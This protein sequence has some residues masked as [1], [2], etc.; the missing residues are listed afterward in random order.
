M[1]ILAALL[2]G[3]VVLVSV[4]YSVDPDEEA[5]ILRFGRFLEITEPG[6]HAKLPFGIDEA[7][8]VRTRRIHKAEFGFRTVEAGV[9]TTYATGDFS[10]ESQ[11]LTGDLNVADVE[12]I[13]QYRIA[14]PKKFLF[15]VR[16]VPKTIRDI[17]ESAMRRVV[18]DRSVNDV[19]TTGRGEIGSS[20][21]SVMQ[22]SI[23]HY[24]MGI[25]IVTVKLQDVNPPKV[26]KASFNDVNAAKQEEER[27][28]NDA[29]Q[30]Y[31]KAIPEA[32]GDALKIVAEAEGY[33]LERVNRAQ[34]EAE[35]FR[36]VQLEYE[37]APKVTASRLYLE[38][39]QKV[40][41]KVDRVVIVDPKVKS[42]VPLLNL[43]QLRAG[44]AK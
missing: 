9:Q 42:V 10:S 24:G 2:G 26:V 22:E 13:V 3:I 33:G 20:V 5:V 39:M 43:E 12:W 11:M 41:Q 27:M 29:W 38:S 21:E 37:K 18:G 7:L 16:N 15:S 4:F 36:Q 1:L 28:I 14:D 34:G 35:R 44:G 6:L 17:A 8:K 25:S 32:K 40:L 30:A 31:N 19:L 23:D